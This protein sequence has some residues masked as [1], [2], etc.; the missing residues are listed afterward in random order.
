VSGDLKKPITQ[1][2]IPEFLENLFPA[3]PYRFSPYNV[4]ETFRAFGREGVKS[5]LIFWSDI[6]KAL[7]ENK[8]GTANLS[9]RTF[10]KSALNPE[11]SVVKRW[12]TLVVLVAIYHFVVVPVRISFV[13]WRSMLDVR[14]LYTDL[15]ADILT[16]LNLLVQINT[17]Y[18]N[19]RASW[20]TDRYKISRRV[21]FRVSLSTI[22]LDWYLD[23]PFL[24][25]V[26][27]WAVMMTRMVQVCFCL[28]RVQRL[29]LLA[30]AP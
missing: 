3:F 21:D 5:R 29:V 25:N 18:L 15:I 4:K 1:K 17:A 19:S 23:L 13:P 10:I 20:V 8:R 16:F 14:A 7:R 28:R 12:N 22:P 24:V 30:A 11:S 26:L 2:Q 27:F 6:R 9:S